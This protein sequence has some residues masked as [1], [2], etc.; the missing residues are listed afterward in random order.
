M[1][2][3]RDGCRRVCAPCES[4]S[5]KGSIVWALCFLISVGLITSSGLAFQSMNDVRKDLETVA[6]ETGGETKRAYERI[7]KSFMAMQLSILSILI[8]IC[9]WLLLTV[10][11]IARKRVGISLS[12][13]HI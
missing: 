9:V 3:A 2:R 8:S 6:D 1:E 10:V 5:S 12:L 4:A 11:E 7:V 13:I